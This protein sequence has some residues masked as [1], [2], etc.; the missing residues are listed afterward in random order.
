MNQIGEQLIKDLTLE[1]LPPDEQMAVVEKF[2][3]T[4]FQAILVRGMEALTDAQKD[5]LD[6]ALKAKPD[7]SQDTV[8][9]F[10][11]E[12]IP[13]F[14]AVIDEEVRRIQSR[15]ADAIAKG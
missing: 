7:G 6:A 9:D 11:M 2:S 15:I 10:L 12:H 8:M 1:S 3:D 5:A 4:L 13:G 14:E